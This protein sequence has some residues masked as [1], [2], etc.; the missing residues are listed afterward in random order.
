MA[1]DVKQENLSEDEA[2]ALE[3]LLAQEAAGDAEAEEAPAKSKKMLLLALVLGVVVVGG[4]VAAYFFLGGKEAP[5][6]EEIQPVKE[7]TPTPE[8]EAAK[9]K[10]RAEKLPHIYTME[11]FFLPITDGKRETGKF[12]HLR[13][14]LL[15]SNAKLSREVDIVLPLMRQT[16]YDILKRKRPRDYFNPRKPIDERLKSEIVTSTNSLLHTGSGKIDDVFFTEFVIR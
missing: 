13:V 5:V 6:E 14:N 12:V 7:E 8:E 16:I 4:G 2:Q 15:L 1:E 11:P 3:E 9:E 10:E